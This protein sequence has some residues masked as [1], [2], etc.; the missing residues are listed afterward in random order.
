MRHHLPSAACSGGRDLFFFALFRDP[1][2]VEPMAEGRGPQII[3]D[4]AEV[5]LQS[6]FPDSL[7]QFRGSAAATAA[8]VL[9]PRSSKS[10]LSIYL[11]LRYMVLLIR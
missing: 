2:V 5:R 11:N 8:A 4:L 3:L 6:F 10:G 7:R 9:W 1:G